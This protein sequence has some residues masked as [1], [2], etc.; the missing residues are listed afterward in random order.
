MYDVYTIRGA[1]IVRR[2][3]F[4]SRREARAAAGLDD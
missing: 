3:L 2:R 4:A 1:K